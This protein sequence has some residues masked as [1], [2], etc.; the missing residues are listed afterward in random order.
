MSPPSKAPKELSKT[1]NSQPNKKKNA[2]HSVTPS[3]PTTNPGLKWFE[4]YYDPVMEVGHPVTNNFLE[5][6]FRTMVQKAATD[7]KF[8]VHREY[9][10]RQ[11]VSRE[12]YERWIEF[13]PPAD[14]YHQIT[15]QL[16]GARRE[17]LGLERRLSENLVLRGAP[18][19]A[20][21]S[22]EFNVEDW[23]TLREWEADLRS[24]GIAATNIQYITQQP[25]ELSPV[26]NSAAVP[27]KLKPNQ[28]TETNDGK[29]L[30]Q[31]EPTEQTD[32]CRDGELGDDGLCEQGDEQDCSD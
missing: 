17:R 24:R 18:L 1:K 26:P 32:S 7:E 5:R 14:E 25:I 31:R 21:K 6:F 2:R 27:I 9:Y 12:R 23:K 20:G 28:A 15:M 19:Y 3:F 30:Q 11:G 8:I 22:K 4:D 16:I 29:I 10:L 13:Y